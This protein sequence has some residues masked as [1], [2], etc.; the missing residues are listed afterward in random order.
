ML[1]YNGR[2]LSTWLHFAHCDGSKEKRDEQKRSLLTK[3][4]LNY[5]KGSMKASQ[6]ARGMTSEAARRMKPEGGT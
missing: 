3:Y 6:T 2:I 5:V 1:I 4:Y